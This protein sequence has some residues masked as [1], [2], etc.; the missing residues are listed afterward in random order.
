MPDPRRIVADSSALIPAFM[1]DGRW[2]VDQRAT[3][4]LNAIERRVVV[5]FAPE[6]LMAEFMN[7]LLRQLTELRTEGQVPNPEIIVES[8][9]LEFQKLS[10]IYTP[11]NELAFL[12]WD[13][14]CQ[15]SVP[16][17]DSW[18]AATAV[19]HDAELWL[20]HPPNDQSGVL[21]KQFGAKVHYLSEE[22]FIQRA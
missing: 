5:A 15:H 21:A 19:H 13:A 7:R 8:Q 3:E 17:P 16:G 18:F 4:L 6:L 11:M 1:P 12:A 20:S 14:P 10:I 2:R 9:W 22:P